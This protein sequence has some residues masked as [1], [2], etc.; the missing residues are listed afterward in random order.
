M[1]RA[2]AEVHY[3]AVLNPQPG[4]LQNTGLSL[5]GTFHPEYAL[6]LDTHQQAYVINKLHS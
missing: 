4:V 1:T 5:S 6:R 2:V 3:P